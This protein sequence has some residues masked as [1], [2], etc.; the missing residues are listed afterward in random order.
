MDSD[1]EQQVSRAERFEFGKN[2]SSFLKVVNETHIAKAEESLQDMLGL[3]TLEGLSFLDAGSGSGLF[4]LAAVRLG[5]KVYS[6][7]FDPSSVACTRELKRRYAPHAENWS[8]EIGSVLDREYLA[9]L[10]KFNIVYSWGVLHHTGNMQQSLDNVIMPLDQKGYLFIAIY[11]DQGRTSQ[12]WRMVK[13]A[14]VSLPPWLRFLVVIPAAMRLRG[15]RTIYDI[16]TG[17][18]FYSWRH[19]SDKRGMSAWHDVIDWVGGYPF[20]VAKPEVIFDFYYSR[21]FELQHMKTCGGRL[22]C[23]QFVFQKK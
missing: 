19:Y 17:K 7:D 5:A 12:V 2:W 10:G 14:Y 4:S 11:N 22:G 20:E 21:G 15:P 13:K 6:F 1:F 23:N 18:P 9:G 16:L 8:I 3:K